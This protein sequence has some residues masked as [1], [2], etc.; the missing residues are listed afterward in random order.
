[1]NELFSCNT[2]YWYVQSDIIYV[3]FFLNT[4][5]VCLNKTFNFFFL[6]YILSWK[7]MKCFQKKKK[8]WIVVGI[9]PYNDKNFIL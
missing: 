5:T 2:G 6:N 4:F 8:S 9:L 7:R 1:M 3:G